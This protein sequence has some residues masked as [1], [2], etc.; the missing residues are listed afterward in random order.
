MNILIDTH[1][2]IWS[3]FE[4]DQLNPQIMALLEDKNNKI[5]VSFLGYYIYGTKKLQEH[6]SIEEPIRK[7]VE[8]VLS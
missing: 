4:S 7:D 6:L 2:L 8:L 1:I 5:F 3:T